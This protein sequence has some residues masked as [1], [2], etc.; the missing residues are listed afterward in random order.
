MNKYIFDVDGTLTPSR[1]TINDDFAVFFSDFCAERDCYLVTGSDREKTIEQV[2][3]EIYSLCKRVYNCSGS[4]AYEGSKNVYSDPWTLPKDTRQW[5]EQTLDD[6]QFG[7]RTGLHIEERSGMVNFSVVGRNATMGERQLYVRWDKEQ[8]ER[9]RIAERFNKKFPDLKATV[10]GDTGIDIAPQGNDKSQ[11]LRDFGHRDT[12]W[13]FGDA[14]DPSGNDYSLAEC[15]E[16][17]W[18][19]PV[20]GWQETYQKLKEIRKND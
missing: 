2:G 5:L 9:V 6:S 4:D 8:L 15:K 13:F 20:S 7:L 17:T 11:I 14:M 18:A 19:I 10:G 1:Q 3:E 16:V 12:L